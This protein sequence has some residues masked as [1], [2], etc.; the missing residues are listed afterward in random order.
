MSQHELEPLRLSL[1]TSLGLTLDYLTTHAH[2]REL[3]SLQELL[4]RHA[5]D[6]AWQ[7]SQEALSL[8]MPKGHQEMPEILR[9]QLAAMERQQ[10]ALAAVSHGGPSMRQEM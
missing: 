9:D 5:A 8:G 2:L 6:V 7:Q 4:A 3:F 1:I 10:H